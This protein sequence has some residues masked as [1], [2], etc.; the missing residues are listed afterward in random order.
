MNTQSFDSFDNQSY[1]NF[2]T[3]AQLERD[4]QTLS[5]IV[6]GIGCDREINDQERK[7]LADWMDRV[8]QY[9]KSDPYRSIL[10]AIANALED[11]IITQEETDNI[12]WL[13]NH[14]IAKSNYYD[15]MTAGIQ[16]LN[17]IVEGIIID[18]VVNEEEIR[19]LE[20]WMEENINLQNC[21]PYDELYSFLMKITADK[22][23]TET[24]QK[25]V[26]AFCKSIVGSNSGSTNADLVDILKQGFCQVDPSISLQEKT[27]CITGNS[28]KYNRREIAEKIELYGGFVTQKVSKNTNYLV[29]CDDKNNC[30]AY[31]CY[32]RKIE[33]TI[34]L[35]KSGHNVAIVHEFDLY[36][37]LA[38][39]E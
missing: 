17:G 26:V 39:F 27:F 1:L 18:D 11:N 25:E 38:S 30:W 36:D 23:I 7:G 13:C 5:G 10:N 9:G 28:K 33:Q 29:V 34:M 3:P 16:K 12:V 4:L 35:R 19:F 20:E 37:T 22:I 2:C 15:M 32:G 14:F 21:W 6:T 31:T 8:K 24:E